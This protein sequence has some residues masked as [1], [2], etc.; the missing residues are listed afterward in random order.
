MHVPSEKY[1]LKSSFYKY[2]AVSTVPKSYRK[3]LETE[4]K[5][6]SITHS[7]DEKVIKI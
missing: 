1:Y 5:L 4:A 7:L 6:I 2:Q 3:I